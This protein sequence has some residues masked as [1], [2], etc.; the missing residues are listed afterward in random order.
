MLVALWCAVSFTL[1]RWAWYRPVVVRGGSIA[2]LLLSAFWTVQRI[3]F[4]S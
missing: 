2:L 3:A 4:A 1:S